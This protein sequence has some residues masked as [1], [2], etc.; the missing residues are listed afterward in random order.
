MVLFLTDFSIFHFSHF[1]FR[2]PLKRTSYEMNYGRRD[3]FIYILFIFRLLNNNQS[4][5]NL[6]KLKINQLTQSAY[7]AHTFQ[8]KNSSSYKKNC[9]CV[10]CLKAHS[11]S[12]TFMFQSET[13]YYIKILTPYFTI[14]W[15]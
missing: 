9:E 11:Y 10:S 14:C 1:H 2:S 12:G 4:P 5:T 8:K 7:V 6:L 15:I 13:N 3:T